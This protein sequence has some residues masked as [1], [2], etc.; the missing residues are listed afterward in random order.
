MSEVRQNRGFGVLLRVVAVIASIVFVFAYAAYVESSSLRG[1]PFIFI[2]GVAAI[3]GFFWSWGG[4]HLAPL[5]EEVLA[6]DKRPPVIYL[7]SFANEKHVSDVE[8]SFSKMFETVGPFVAI[9]APGERLPPLGAAR[10]YLE[11]DNWQA[12]VAEFLQRAKLVLIYGG[13]TPGLGWE[14]G[15]VRELLHPS[16]AVV[17]VPNDKSGYEK[18][19]ETAQRAAGI[20][21]PGFPSG[22]QMKYAT[23][24]V[25]GFLTFDNNWHSHFTALPKAANRGS[26]TP[27]NYNAE[28]GRAWAALA[29]VYGRLGLKVPKPKRNWFMLYFRIVQFYL[30]LVLVL[31]ALFFAMWGLGIIGVDDQA[32]PFWI[33]F[34]HLI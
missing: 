21:L 13:E 25:A 15:K 18:F 32:G 8:Q 3:G 27:Y 9:G 16:R 29:E 20:E 6:N 12:K 11:D 33:G 4:R 22:G 17:M 2:G 1:N 31:I 7:R 30:L 5:A 14:V 28:T 23:P 10:L 24:G 34:D 19:R 26:G